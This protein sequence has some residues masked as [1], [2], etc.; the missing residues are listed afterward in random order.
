[1]ILASAQVDALGKASEEEAQRLER[2]REDM[3]ATLHEVASDLGRLAL[4]Y[5]TQVGRRPP[6][7][8]CAGPA[9]SLLPAPHLCCCLAALPHIPFFYEPSTGGSCL[10]SGILCSSAAP[11][12]RRRT[13][14]PST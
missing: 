2:E 10:T 13:R 7:R 8:P 14:S 9:L 6:H 4:L 1:M 3:E 12:A 5:R 11:R